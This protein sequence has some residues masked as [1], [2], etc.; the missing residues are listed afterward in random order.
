MKKI[1]LLLLAAFLMLNVS[2]Q[3]QGLQKGDF[4]LNVGT[5]IGYKGFPLEVSGSYG[6]VDDLFHLDGLTLSVGGYLGMSFFAGTEFYNWSW[7]NYAGTRILPAVRVLAHYTFF[8]KL[9]VFAGPALGVT[10]DRS[11]SFYDTDN[12]FYLY[13][14]VAAGAKYYFTEKF[15]VYAET[16]YSIGYFMAGITLKL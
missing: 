4:G 6:I 15:G 5:G 1:Y 7:Y 13:G 10:I 2:V 16:G 8:D 12:G 3:S 14:S 11:T 9:E